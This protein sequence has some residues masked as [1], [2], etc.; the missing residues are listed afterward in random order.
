MTK[1]Q[2]FF[3]KVHPHK[4]KRADT[5][6][7]QSYEEL[8]AELLRNEALAEVP[9]KKL[10]FG[11]GATPTFSHPEQMAIALE[12]YFNN[13][14][15]EEWTLTGVALHLGLTYGG[16]MNYEE[17]NKEFHELIERARMFV[18][19][20]YEKSLRKDG[21]TGDIFALKNLGW[22]DKQEVANTHQV[23]MMPS[24]TKTNDN[25]N[26]EELVFEVGNVIEHKE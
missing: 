20:A 9:K 23:V 8:E 22:K 5:S 7:V 16:F 26:K 11:V 10:R 21:R 6:N 18:H 12:D 2:G 19:N 17:K 14:K 1:K 4:D 25:G 15:E 3:G 24:I 13:T